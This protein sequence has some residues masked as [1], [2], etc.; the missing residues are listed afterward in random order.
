VLSGQAARALNSAFE[1]RLFAKGL[2]IGRVTVEI[3]PAQAELAGGTATVT[4]RA[5]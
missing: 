4:A 3:T 2:P 1:T 5:R